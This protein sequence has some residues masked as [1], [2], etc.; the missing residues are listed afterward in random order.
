MTQKEN[1]H[2]QN[3][4]GGILLQINLKK[5]TKRL[6]MKIIQDNNRH[7]QLSIMITVGGL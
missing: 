6:R 4:F 3:V 2:D 1:G 5:Q 7:S